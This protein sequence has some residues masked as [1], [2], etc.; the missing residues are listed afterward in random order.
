MISNLFSLDYMLVGIH[1]SFS[2]SYLARIH[3]LRRG[4]QSHLVI[5][6]PDTHK[7]D[8]V[9]TRLNHRVEINQR[10]L[11]LEERIQILSRFLRES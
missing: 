5:Q 6:E 2:I 9:D 3:I 1:S 4:Y 10:D 7:R 8:R 11:S